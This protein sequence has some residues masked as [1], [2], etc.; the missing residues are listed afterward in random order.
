MIKLADITEIVLTA[1]FTAIATAIATTKLKDRSERIKVYKG[2]LQ[3]IGQNIQFAKHNIDK[4]EEF[5]FE[6]VLFFRD[7]F[8]NM[9]KARGYFLDLPFDL[10]T[11]LHKI[12]IKQY[13]IG[14][15]KNQLATLLK[16]GLRAETARETMTKK[17]NG[18]L[19]KLNEAKELLEKKLD[20]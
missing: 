2:F 18:L 13:E 5:A 16:S 17:I 19:P 15:E 1:V 10:R 11:L 9:S 4:L 12:Y 3:E 7:D 8:Y 20:P 14:L 6:K